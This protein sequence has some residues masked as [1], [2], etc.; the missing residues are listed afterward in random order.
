MPEVTDA[1][2]IG[3]TAALVCRLLADGPDARRQVLWCPRQEPAAGGAPY[4]LGL[5][6]LGL[7]AHNVIWVDAPDDQARLD[8][9]EEALRCPGLGCVVVEVAAAGSPGVKGG[10]RG[11]ADALSVATRR[12]QLAAEAGGV[13]GL[14][15]TPETLE[16]DRNTA[17]SE[18]GRQ[19][20][21]GLG[22]YLET[23]WRVA[24]L[25]AASPLMTGE[26]RE[27]LLDWRPRWHVALE[28][29]RG[30]RPGA[31]PVLWTGTDDANS[32]GCFTLLNQPVYR[33]NS[34]SHTPPQPGRNTIPSAQPASKVAETGR[35]VA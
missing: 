26:S 14:V 11:G 23:R 34:P 32:G 12:L 35:R 27:D 4:G 10:G 13:T 31:W 9:A 18:A 20:M 3:F 29:A 2:P 22:A 16:A 19:G 28:R 30:G 8:I 1:A 15:L 24:S 33:E 17:S 7:P 5:A 25:P 21:A 6:R